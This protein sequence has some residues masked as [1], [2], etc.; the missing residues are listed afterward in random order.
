[1]SY[2]VRFNDMPWRKVDR[3]HWVALTGEE[4]AGVDNFSQVVYGTP[5][6]RVEGTTTDPDIIGAPTFTLVSVGR[7]PA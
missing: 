4:H 3:E 1:M 2:W 6:R 7:E 5:D